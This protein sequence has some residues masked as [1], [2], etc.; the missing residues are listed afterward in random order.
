MKNEGDQMIINHVDKGVSVSIGGDEASQLTM[1]SSAAIA[2]QGNL[3]MSDK[4]FMFIM[5]MSFKACKDN[6]NKSIEIDAGKIK[7]IIEHEKDK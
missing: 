1:L 2:V 7:D 3:G 5:L 4:D 6:L